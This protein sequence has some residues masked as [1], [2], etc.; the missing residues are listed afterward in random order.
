MGAEFTPVWL[1]ATSFCRNC[2]LFPVRK[3]R[4]TLLATQEDGVGYRNEDS[5]LLLLLSDVGPGPRRSF[6]GACQI[7]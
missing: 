7:P 6:R 3:L 5:V 1:G 2:A 4:S